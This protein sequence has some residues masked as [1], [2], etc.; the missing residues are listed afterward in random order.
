MNCQAITSE[1]SFPVYRLRIPR[2]C[3]NRKDSKTDI[4]G[5]QRTSCENAAATLPDRPFLGWHQDA[6]VNLPRQPRLPPGTSTATGC[7]SQ[8]ST[9]A[10]PSIHALL[11]V[12]ILTPC[13]RYIVPATSQ[14]CHQRHRHLSISDAARLLEPG[15]TECIRSVTCACRDSTT[16]ALQHRPRA[17]TSTNRAQRMAQTVPRLWRFRLLARSKHATRRHP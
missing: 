6:D 2:A 9:A 14:P 11:R 16:F 12:Q 10:I 5:G 1:A 15:Q 4:L 7:K 13:R 3:P 8:K 17:Q